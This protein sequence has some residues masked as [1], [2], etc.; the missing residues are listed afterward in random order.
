MQTSTQQGVAMTPHMAAAVPTFLSD[1]GL[2]G[3]DTKRG[4][5]WQTNEVFTNSNQR[6][7]TQCALPSEQC[8]QE[9]RQSRCHGALTTNSMQIQVSDDVPQL[10]ISHI[11]CVDNEKP[12]TCSVVVG[13]T[14]DKISALQS[15]LPPKPSFPESD[16]RHSC[17]KTGRG[18]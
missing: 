17:H 4:F 2:V 9:S 7:G 12:K 5:E 3:S 14:R 6:I 13:T 16:Y 11:P 15:D 10:G 8:G 18:F 1:D